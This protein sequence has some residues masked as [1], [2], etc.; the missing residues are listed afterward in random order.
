MAHGSSS[1]R[2]D[3]L[4]DIVDLKG[5]VAI[6]T[7]G[8]TGIGY[9]TVQHLVRGG[10][11]VY[12]A[13]R[14]E[15][16]AMRAIE[17]LRLEG[18]APGNGQVAWLKLDLSD[19]RDAKKAAE[20]FLTMEKRLDILINNAGLVMTPYEMTAHGV[21]TLATVNYIS[22]FI[23]TRTLLPL[24]SQTAKEPGSDVR[25]VN[26]TSIA[27]KMVPS[28]LSFKNIEDLNVKYNMHLLPGFRRYALSKFMILLWTITLQK[29]ILA[30]ESLAPITVIA[31]HPG[32]VDTFTQNW[33]FPAFSKWLV[34]LA[35]ADPVHGAY[36]SVFASASK[37]VAA[38]KV[39]YRGVYLESS[40]TGRITEV[41]KSLQNE[42]LGAQLWD[43][44]EKFLEDLA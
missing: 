3:P 12:L 6:V 20:D 40:P 32:G 30:A 2:F 16:R 17:T 4:A 33:P 10:A 24:L 21:T 18:F 35:I 27:H 7:G 43:I 11:T 41:G 42:E 38:D 15:E 37:D 26:L 25:I 13:A 44:T 5:R 14:N 28:S 19:P 9:A 22:P 34:G 8:N 36:N 31:I 39:K 23:F 29:R 1:R